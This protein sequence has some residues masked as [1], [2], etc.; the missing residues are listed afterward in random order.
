MCQKL[1]IFHRIFHRVHP[2]IPPQARVKVEHGSEDLLGFL[3]SPGD[4]LQLT[5]ENHDDNSEINHKCI[6]PAGPF[7]IAIFDYQIV[8]KTRYGSENRYPVS[9]T[10]LIMTIVPNYSNGQFEGVPPCSDKPMA[11]ILSATY[12]KNLRFYP[13]LST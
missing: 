7:S 13:I 4:P 5:M 6:F 2:Q 10:L 9:S 8:T 3:S 1:M 11:I 12:P